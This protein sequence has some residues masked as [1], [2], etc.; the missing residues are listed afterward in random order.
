[1]QRLDVVAFGHECLPHKPRLGMVTAAE[2][3]TECIRCNKT[4]SADLKF[5]SVL[6]Y[7]G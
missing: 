5:M 6:L 2:K 7:V 3:N 4:I 1:V